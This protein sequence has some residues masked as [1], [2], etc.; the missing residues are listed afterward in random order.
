MPTATTHPS[1]GSRK[2]SFPSHGLK[3]V[4]DLYLP[5][6][7]AP[8]RKKAAIIVSHPMTG[9]KEQTAGLHA[10]QLAENGFV[11]LAFDAA[12]QG[13]SEGEPR[14][15]EDPAQR[16]EDNRAA[17]TY[18]TTLGDEVDPERIGAIGICA[19]GGY[20]PFAAQTDL[21]MKAVATVSGVDVGRLTREGIKGTGSVVDASALRQGLEAA[22]KARTAEAK[23][24]AT[25]TTFILFPDPE[26]MPEEAAPLYKEGT[27]YYRTPRGQHE[28]ATNLLPNRSTDLM[29][30]YD[31][32]AFI[33]MISPRPLLMIAGSEADTRYFSED[34]IKAAKEPKELFIV[35]GKTHIGLYDDTSKSMPK[36]VDFFEKALCN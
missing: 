17:V 13:E 23:G 21:R 22:G 5:P 32:F 30:N 9:V 6:G 15:L 26:N 31:S 18:L 29:A 1:T 3:V 27:W 28:R 16:A 36:L 25:E 10:R 34:A 12:Y 24:A 14:G 4:G 2:V 19:S 33:G 20:T 35:D 11:T 8:D 7:S